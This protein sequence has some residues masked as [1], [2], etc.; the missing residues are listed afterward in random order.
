MAAV[1]TQKIIS[2]NA[3]RNNG[4]T[5]MFG[6][7]NASVTNITGKTGIAKK[8]NNLTTPKAAN[9][10]KTQ[11]ALAGGTFAYMGVGEFMFMNYTGSKI[12]GSAQ[13][14]P[15][16]RGARGTKPLYSAR[17]TR[18]YTYLGA[19]PFTLA[20]SNGNTS[21]TFNASTDSLDF[22]RDD[23]NTNPYTDVAGEFVFQSTGRLP[24][25]NSG[26]H[27]YYSYTKSK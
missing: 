12:N 18:T 17:T 26:N 1:T 19:N 23:A 27:K 2:A 8:T 13:S 10:A 3:K 7:A 11:K 24:S 20:F 14:A 9:T 5:L 22:G 25:Q 6:T 15:Y 21:V 16:I 4:G